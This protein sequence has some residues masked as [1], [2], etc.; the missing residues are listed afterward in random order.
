MPCYDS[1][2]EPEYVAQA[3]VAA[4]RDEWLHNSPVAEMLCSVLGTLS[5]TELAK[6]SIH[7]Q[8]WWN[9]HKDRDIAI[10]VKKIQEQKR[11]DEK[12]KQKEAVFKTAKQLG[13]TPRELKRILNDPE[14]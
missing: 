10:A 1:R 7:V 8:R 2:C 9:A 14:I 11:R 13:L 3:A 6:Q 4:A 5:A 12:L